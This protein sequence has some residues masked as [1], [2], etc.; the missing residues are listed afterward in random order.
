M[1]AEPMHETKEKKEHEGE[2]KEAHIQQ[3]TRPGQTTGRETSIVR[4]AGST[5]NGDFELSH[6]IAR[7]KG[8]GY[9]MAHA[10]SLAIERK[11]GINPGIKIGTLS[12]QQIESIES[13]LKNPGANDVPGFLL[14]RRKDME[15]GTDM[16][17]IATD[18]IVKTRQDIDNDVKIQTWRGFRHQYGQKVRGQR[19]RSTGRTGATIG[20][21][22]KKEVPGAAA[23][24]GAAQAQQASAKPTGGTGAAAAPKAAPPGK[25][26]AAKPAAPAK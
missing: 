17:F 8:I 24:A 21:T 7:V 11:L 16:H 23:A 14:N 10:V 1:A 20:V 22:K 25:P 6:A 18:L 3:K 13:I 4:I 9:N 26:A 15:T 12:E 19:T 5:L 2:S